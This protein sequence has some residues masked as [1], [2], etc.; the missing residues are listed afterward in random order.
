MEG[1]ADPDRRGFAEEN[2]HYPLRPFP[3]TFRPRARI[4]LGLYLGDPFAY[5]AYDPSVYP[6]EYGYV[7]PDVGY[8]GLT[9]DVAP[10]NALVYVDGHYAGTVSEF[11]SP[12][13]PL[14]LGEG[15]HQIHIEAPG[16]QPLDF[17]VQVNA[18]QIV[19][20]RAELA[21]L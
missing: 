3:H 14:T 16:F 8:G 2:H 18:G 11:Y 7:A 20:Y 12:N 21:L 5:P 4:G 15:R 19:P 17:D 6:P 10:P 9:L 13:Q 1:R